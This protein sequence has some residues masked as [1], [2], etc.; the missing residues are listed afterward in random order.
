MAFPVI[1]TGE[2][3]RIVANKRLMDSLPVMLTADALS[4]RQSAYRSANKNARVGIP[5]RARQYR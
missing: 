4:Q 3:K 5:T 1:M 2:S